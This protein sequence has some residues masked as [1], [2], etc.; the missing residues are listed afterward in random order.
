ME[1]VLQHCEEAVDVIRCDCSESAYPERALFFYL[2][3]IDGEAALIA[4]V[5]HLVEIPRGP[6]GI[7]H[8]DDELALELRSYN[9]LKPETAQPFMH[10]AS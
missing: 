1:R 7:P 8:S 3:G 4:V 5:V 2:A 9:L 10:V 6:I